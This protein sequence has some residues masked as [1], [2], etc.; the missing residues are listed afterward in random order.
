MVARRPHRA[1]LNRR[2]G[3]HA[4]AAASP[5]AP[6]APTARPPRP[7]RRIP[8][9]RR[10]RNPTVP[11]VTP[12]RP[13]RS[14][15][16]PRRRGRLRS[17][18]TY[19]RRIYIA[20]G[21]TSRGRRARLG[22]D[23]DPARRSP[24]PA[25]RRQSRVTETPW[26]WNG[27]PHR[28][29]PATT[30]TAAP[31]PRGRSTPRRCPRDLRARRRRVGQEQCY[32]CGRDTSREATLEGEPSAAHCAR[33]RD[34]F[35]PAAPRGPRGATAGQCQSDLGPNTESDLAGYLVLR[36]DV[37]RR[38]VD[39][40]HRGADPRDVVSRRHGQ[41]GMRYV[42]AIVAVDAATPPNVSA[43]SPRVEETPVKETRPRSVHR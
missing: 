22:T 14:R 38:R 32:Q 40:A 24:G 4:P 37:A 5:T 19:A 39:G 16:Q 23:D 42:Y 11:A 2:S 27:L 7:P 36:G 10:R 6:T 25:G 21:V 30:S 1:R 13:R 43:Q 26:S 33:P 20:R 29:Q 41:A 28:R 12:A 31:T 8:P 35:A 34:T 3:R 18:R 15:P 17:V 9:P